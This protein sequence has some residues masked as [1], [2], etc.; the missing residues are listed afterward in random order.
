MVTTPEQ[1][2]SDVSQDLDRI[3]TKGD[4]D[5]EYCQDLWN[6]KYR[7]YRLLDGSACNE[8]DT[9]AEVAMLFYA[10]MYGLAAVGNSHYSGKLIR[11]LLEK[12]H[13]SYGQEECLLMET[14]MSKKVRSLSMPMQEWMSSYFVSGKSITKE[15]ETILHLSEAKPKKAKSKNKGKVPYTL[16][17]NCKNQSDRI[18]RLTLLMRKWQEWRW[19]EEPRQTDDFISLFDGEPHYCNIQ[20]V[21]KGYVLTEMMKQLL[22]Q[23]YI[24]RTTGCSARSLVKNQFSKTPDNNNSRLD[25][26]ES[27]RIGFSLLILDYSKPLPSP[28]RGTSDDLDI[29]DAAFQEVYSGELHTTK[30]LN[31]RY[32]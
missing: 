7:E 29:S 14:L 26:E 4:P 16:S 31:K 22:S 30:D 21:G 32:A 17:Y 5:A 6:N 13:R 11:T 9:K 28:D 10:L 24:T 1:L 15:I 3:L 18:R 12:I 25:D 27:D 19:I 20:W 23:S 8:N 2:F